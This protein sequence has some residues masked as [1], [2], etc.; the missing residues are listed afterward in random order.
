MN[1]ILFILVLILS[2]S[3]AANSDQS[4]FL[5]KSIEVTTKSGE[6]FQGT[7]VYESSDYLTIRDV[8]NISISIPIENVSNISEYVYTVKTKSTKYHSD[9]IKSEN[10]SSVTIKKEEKT[11]LTTPRNRIRSITRPVQTWLNIKSPSEETYRH[12]DTNDVEARGNYSSLDTLKV[13]QK[14]RYQPLEPEKESDSDE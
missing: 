14:D 3:I 13:D 5:N 12:I 10:G 11:I 2:I 6:S 8:D 1:R 7:L 4:L 9:S